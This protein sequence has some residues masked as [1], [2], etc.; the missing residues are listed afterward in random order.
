MFRS[1]KAGKLVTEQEKV[2]DLIVEAREKALSGNREKALELIRKAI[3]MDPDEQVITD[4]ILAM[5]KGAWERAPRAPREPAT[6][7]P[8]ETTAP[9]AADPRLEKALSL[10][11]RYRLEGDNAKAL[12]C[13]KKAAR[14]FPDNTLVKKRLSSLTTTL[15]AETMVSVA[16]KRM[17]EGDMAAAVLAARQA[18][19]ILPGVSG[20]EELLS[21]ME[22][23]SETGFGT[24]PEPSSEAGFDWDDD[25]D[26]DWEEEEEVVLMDD[27]GGSVEDLIER[28][29]L[30]VRED[31]WED[32]A[33]LVREGVAAFPENELLESFN[34][35]FKRLGLN[36]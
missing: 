31:R 33:V 22:A 13:L 5:E 25:D 21:D 32:A 18:F 27:A 30:L 7:T 6:A 29:R 34:I 1:S 4:S 10:S 8:A 12:A 26:E 19:H 16:R 2:R 28:I 24:E 11:K 15:Q 23:S 35:K 14:L 17:D 20:L 36:G 9:E 3:A